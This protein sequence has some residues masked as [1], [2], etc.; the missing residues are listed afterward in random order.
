[1]AVQAWQHFLDAAAEATDCLGQSVEVH[2]GLY[3][4]F[5]HGGDNLWGHAFAGG[6]GPRYT[7]VQLA[8]YPA[9]RHLQ[10][11]VGLKTLGREPWGAETG[12]PSNTETAVS[13]LKTKTTMP[14]LKA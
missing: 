9:D 13:Q 11:P 3:K 14:A 1:M 12:A 7:Q 2:G 5:G 8:Q 10:H 6:L 4:V